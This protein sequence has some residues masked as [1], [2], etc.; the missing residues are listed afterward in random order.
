MLGFSLQKIIVLAVVIAAVW[1]G[2][3]FV[4]RLDESRKK[5]VREALRAARGRASGRAAKPRAEAAEDMVRCEACDAFV[6]ARG[7]T[8]CG[9]DDCPYPG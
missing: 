5:T 9:R 2:F 1:Y 3:K 4:G 8:A 6:A 7:A